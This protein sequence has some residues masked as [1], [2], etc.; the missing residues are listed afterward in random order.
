MTATQI[1]ARKLS[2]GMDYSLRSLST[3][4]TEW[5]MTQFLW[6]WFA[7][8][9]AAKEQRPQLGRAMWRNNRNIFIAPA[10]P[11]KSAQVKK[12][13][14]AQSQPRE[15]R[16]LT[17]MWKH[18][19]LLC[20][21][22]EWIIPINVLMILPSWQISVNAAIGSVSESLTV[23]L[24]ISVYQHLQKRPCVMT[25]RLSASCTIYISP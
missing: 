17:Q 21:A 19:C 5:G 22:L 2:N 1:H 13:S 11:S 20:S 16:S 18:S 6:Q 9:H 10:Q 12:N 23:H 3:N 7:G 14:C 8:W 4:Q 24:Q 15:D 25:E